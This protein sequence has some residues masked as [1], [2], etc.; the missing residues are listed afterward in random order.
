[1]AKFSG[2]NR[3]PRRV[4]VAAPI[5]T[6]RTRVL[7][8][9]GGVGYARDAESDLFVLAATNMVGEDTFYERAATRDARFVD[10]VR[11]VTET[12][13]AFIAGA[14]VDAGK[15]GL[16]QYLRETMLMRSAAVVMAA[17]YVAAGGAGGRTVIA[18]ALRRADEPAEMLGY[19]LATHGRKIPM[20]VKRGVADAARRLY[21][22]RAAMRYDG[23]GRQIRM[24]DVLELAHPSP[25]D[26][27]QSAL[28]KHLLD[29]RHHDD[30]V[31]DPSVLPM[32]AAAA[33][34][35]AVP[36]DERRDVLRQ[37]GASALA[38]AGF[39]WE[40]LSGWLPG[41]M[42]AAAW[43]AVIPSMGAMALVRNL[44]NFDEAGIGEAAVDA[45]IAKVTDATEVAQAR[46]FPYQIWAAYKHA[47]SD[48]WKRALGRTLDL[49]V[50]NIP[51]LDGTLV[52]I[53]TSGSM[54]APVSNRSRL[55]RVEVAA[56]MAMATAKRAR[57]VDIVIY[58]QGNAPV[59]VPRGEAVLSGVDRV[60]RSVGSVGHATY[61]HTAIARWYS[62][63]RHRRVVV[64]TD[65]QQHD[66]GHVRLDH[67]PLIYTFNLA[68]YR[69]SA[70]SAGERGRYTLA[71]FTDATFTL[72]D[73]LERGRDAEW[74][75]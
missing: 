71:G 74:P 28:F 15:V 12:N 43:E 36:V 25:R 51:Q 32:L 62:P 3:K 18:R 13:P 67:V 39:S 29:R 73:V 55:Q 37:R 49:T 42:D 64:F 58:G 56:V 35:D 48:N 30:A 23:L 5:R 38:E 16:A 75:F 44:R 26:A 33:A 57:D 1:M 20:P 27:A 6:L 7:T 59:R 41:G 4:N 69:P 61:G 19:W 47:P 10:L 40:R 52:V 17:E 70:L 34:L 53:D 45:V 54:Q 8:H 63:R 66:A 14:D 50:A 72:M 60:V 31:A 11:E 68:G 22:E 21:T 46:L 65:D 9:E 2:T 24:A